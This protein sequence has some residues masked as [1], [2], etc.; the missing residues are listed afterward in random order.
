MKRFLLIALLL[1][2]T[3][4]NRS[5]T[6]HGS[7]ATVIRI[8]GSSTMERLL[9]SWA[10]AYAGA[11][12]DV[13]IVIESTASADGVQSLTGYHADICASSR[14][15]LPEEAKTMLRIR[16]SI[17]FV[18][19]C[20]MDAL[21]VY[22]HPENPVSSLT[23]EQVRGIFSGAIASWDAIGGNRQPIEVFV[24]NPESGTGWYFREHVLLGMPY[25]SMATECN[26][27]E[28][29]VNA[30]GHHPNGIG[31]GG[32]AYGPNLRHLAIDGVAPTLENVRNDRY[33]ITRYL[34]F[35]T[36]DQPKGDIQKFI[37]WT[38]SEEGQRIAQEAGFIPLYTS[39]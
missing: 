5:I 32:T 4:A 19:R 25:S 21:S 26:G 29:V 28:A 17:G 39:Q 15:L 23:M 33:P 22:V 35:I 10:D 24:R 3:C 1:L 37:N 36:V 30:V 6:R 20:A 18:T 27:T 12:R 16:N 31:Y 8:A 34:Y 11:Y 9:I 38:L 13:S 2:P 14:S 7:G